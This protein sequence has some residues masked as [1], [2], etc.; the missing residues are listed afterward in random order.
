MTAVFWSLF[1]RS[2][3]IVGAAEILARLSRRSPAAFRHRILAA[4][5]TLLLIWP[6]VSAIVPE[7]QLPVWGHSAAVDGGVTVRQTAILIAPHGAPAST[8]YAP[9]VLVVLWLAGV[10]AALMPVVIGYFT[11]LRISRRAAQVA[12]GAWTE[13][14]DQLCA[15]LAIARRPELLIAKASL[16]PMTFGLRRSRILLPSECVAWSEF[17]LKAVLLHELAHIARRDLQVQ[18]LATAITA[19]WWFQPLCWVCRGSLRRESERACDAVA[20]ASGL[21]ASEYAAELLK[22]A[23]SFRNSQR[24]PAAAI[25][26]ARP[27]RLEGR[28]HAILSIQPQRAMRTPAVI[29]FSVLTLLAVAASAVTLTPKQESNFRGGLNMKRTLLSGLLA[30]TGLSAATIGGSLFDPSGA[31]IPNAKVSVYDPDNSTR[32][33]TTTAPDGKFSFEGLP[34]GQYIL[35]VEKEGFASLFREFNVQTESN[36]ERG[37][38]LNPGEP[39]IPPEKTASPE[40]LNPHQLRVRGEVEQGNLTKRVNPVYPAAAKSAHVTGTVELEVSISKQGVPE[41]I[42]VVRSPSDDLTQSAL[43]AVRQWRYRPM[44]LNG[45]PVDIVTDV[46]VNYTLSQ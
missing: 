16:T 35:H 17:R 4:G 10:G 9:W 28:L 21:R 44:L 6:A 46:I 7:F 37:L 39:G 12:E 14:L 3:I 11:V 32:Q 25:A 42:R 1:I 31:A 26:M 19:V 22:I 8:P 15:E 2:A 34:A 33:E 27:G 24:W 40:P 29:A 30:A 18:I 45:Q 41:D 36:V 43:E 20:V 13:L 38:V 5:F 23:H